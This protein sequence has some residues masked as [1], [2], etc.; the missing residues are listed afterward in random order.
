MTDCVSLSLHRKYRSPTANSCHSHQNV[1]I[2][3]ENPTKRVIYCVDDMILVK[4]SLAQKL[5][6]YERHLSKVKSSRVVSSRVV[7]SRVES[8]RVVSSRVGQ[9]E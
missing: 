7:S 6:I 2:S 4:G 9:V 3:Q 5:P 8:S 1:E